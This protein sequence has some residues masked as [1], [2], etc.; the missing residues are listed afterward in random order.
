MTREEMSQKICPYT[1][2]GRDDPKSC[3]LERCVAFQI[4]KIFSTDKSVIG[5]PIEVIEHG[6]STF[7][8]ID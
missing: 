8:S 6:C 1:L 5:K 3:I 2:G 4:K 7:N